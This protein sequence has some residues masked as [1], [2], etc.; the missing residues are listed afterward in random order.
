MF[1]RY[2]KDPPKKT[3][4]AKGLALSENFGLRRLVLEDCVRHHTVGLDDVSRHA[5]TAAPRD[6][7]KLALMINLL[8]RADGA[9]I[10][11][12]TEA[13]GWLAH[14][15]RA[16]ITG[17]RKRGYAVTRE[18]IGAGESGTGSRA[19]LPVAEIA[20]QSRRRQWTAA[21]TPN[22]RRSG[23]RM[24]RTWPLRLKRVGS[25]LLRRT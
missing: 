13:T 18:R 21:V 1:K 24:G 6:G 11:D 8:R 15:T 2:E 20:C 12:L 7:S 14:T 19:P 10:V 16:A 23:R 9:T 4:S 17:L 3:L 5:P 25:R 22:L